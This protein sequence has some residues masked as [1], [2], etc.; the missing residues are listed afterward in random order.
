MK[1]LRYLNIFTILIIYTLLMFYIGWN[2]W[3][4]LSTVFGWESWGYYAFLVGFISYAYILVQVFK[5]LPFL[6]TIGSIWFAVIQYALMLL[7]IA[8]I[9]V[10]LLQF[11]VEKEAAIIWTGAAVLAAFIFIFAYGVF[12]AYSPV[13]RKY[14]VHIPKK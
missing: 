1:N 9:T 12:N 8:D 3:V 10:F 13:V 6:R 7:P 2:G 4:W 11:S 14:E 5:F